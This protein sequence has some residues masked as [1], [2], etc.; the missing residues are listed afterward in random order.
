MK[1]SGRI[2]LL[3]SGVL[4]TCMGIF[5]VVSAMLVQLGT[6]E[7]REE[8]STFT[9][10]MWLFCG[11]CYLTVGVAG[12]IFG[13]N[14]KR[15]RFLLFFGFIALYT[16][17]LSAFL[18]A[19]YNW[20]SLA[21][22]LAG[23]A[24]CI[25]FIVGARKNQSHVAVNDWGY[26][27]ISPFFLIFIAFIA[28]PIYN[29]FHM[30]LTSATIRGGGWQTE[31]IGFDNFRELWNNRMFRTAVQNTWVLW[32]F[33]FIP[34]MVLALVLA[35]MFTSTTYKLRFKG[36]FKVMYYLPNLMMPVTIAALF[37]VY[38]SLHGPVNQ[39]MVQ[40]L[41]IWDSAR[42][43]TQIVMDTRIV[44]VFLQTW[45]WF[46]QTAI[47]LVA[48]MTSISP[49][50]YE[51][52]MIDGAS[53]AKMFFKITIPLLKPVL[54]F[55]LVTSLV[56]GLGMFD[57][58]LLFSQSQFGNPQNAVLTVN[59][60]MNVR[61]SFQGG[62]QFGSAAAISVILFMMSSVVAL[63]IFRI[64]GARSEERHEKREIRRAK[65][66]EARVKKMLK[67]MNQN[68]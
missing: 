48:G 12:G 43:F 68:G 27:F 58:P 65:K 32:I 46:G 41:G 1:T 47:V 60:F 25:C 35:A 64:F 44:V 16:F 2:Y 42:D 23:L 17:A 50:F 19:A 66:E 4:L 31:Y 63:I 3:I 10:G 56:G 57:I 45:M 38:L 55:V 8:L 53:Q 7:L 21:A 33:N 18:I 14:P 15:A 51:S 54:L 39:F 59:M 40:T 24:V 13:S 9:F 34:Q 61:R 62:F 52:A 5:A 28:Y 36:F 26:I 30:S 6:W 29:T 20:T 11:L 67:G 49:T 22:V 37:N